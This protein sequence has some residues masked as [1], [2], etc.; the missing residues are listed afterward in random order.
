MKR[1]ASF[2]ILLSVVFLLFFIQIVA[3]EQIIVT[4]TSYDAKWTAPESGTYQFTI[5]GGAV[6]GGNGV[7]PDVCGACLDGRCYVALVNVYVN[8]P[9]SWGQISS[10]PV[11]PISPDYSLGSEPYPSVAAAE[12]ATIGNYVDIPLNKG[13]QLI[14]T[15]RD[16]QTSYPDNSGSI[17][18]DVQIPIVPDIS[19]TWS[20]TYNN[21]GVEQYS[22]VYTITQNAAQFSGTAA[23]VI[24]SSN[25]AP[26]DVGKSITYNFQG[27]IDENGNIHITGNVATAPPEI[28]S[29]CGAWDATY[30]LSEDGKTIFFS[31]SDQYGNSLDILLH[32]GTPN[33]PPQVF[34]TYSPI[35]PNDNEKITFDASLSQDPDGKIISYQWDFGNGEIITKKSSMISNKYKDPGQYLVKLTVTDNKGASSS[36]TKPIIIEC[37]K[38]KIEVRAHPIPQFPLAYHLFIIYTDPNGKEFYFRGGP[39]KKSPVVIV[40]ESKKYKPNTP[41]WYPGAP[42][43]TAL[44][45]WESFNKDQCF[46]GE[47]NRIESL[48]IPYRIL[49]PNSNTVVS[50]LLDNCDVQRVK[51]NVDAPGW[52]SGNL[53]NL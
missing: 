34:F 23:F 50:T 15:I 43:V 38:C 41:D 1:F 42:T 4:G 45:G 26:Q 14:F 32:R 19:G 10:C 18:I 48:K 21:V 49:G 31:G 47:L 16:Y 3:A 36:I 7:S 13:D 51:P 35:S 11:V 24:T 20:G 17:T 9:I 29:R 46:G 37:P 22:S 28:Y 8:R 30:Q 2:K 25:Y 39:S 6:R 44:S 40:T 27:T 5:T 33:Q 12:A 52:N 53:D